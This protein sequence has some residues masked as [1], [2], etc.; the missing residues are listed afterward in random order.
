MT[1]DGGLL[2]NF[3]HAVL[4]SKAKKAAESRS[5]RKLR[6]TESQGRK[7]VTPHI[8]LVTCVLSMSQISR[9]LPRGIQ[10]CGSQQHV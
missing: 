1:Q 2:L 4:P 9:L 10:P 3:K 8:C 5:L 7:C 6:Q